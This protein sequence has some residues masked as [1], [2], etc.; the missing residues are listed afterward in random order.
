MQQT[1]RRPPAAWALAVVP[2]TVLAVVVGLL[3]TGASAP[4][5]VADPG[6][7]TRW[8]AP[9]AGALSQLAAAVVLG[10]LLLLL[11]VLVP[12]TDGARGGTAWERTRAAVTVAGPAWALLSLADLV[13]GYSTVAGRPLTDPSFGSE[14]AYYVTELS[15]GRAALVVCVMA[16][17]AA[18]A[19]VGVTGYRSGALAL[20]LATAVLIPIA[21]TGHAAGSA[22]HDLGMSALF[23]HVLAAAVWVGGLVL[24]ALVASRI[25][26]VAAVASRFSTIAGWCF[27]GIAVSGVAVSWIRLGSLDVLASGYG[28]LV[29]AKVAAFLALGLAG[30][31]HRRRTIAALGAASGRGPFWRLIGVEIALVGVASGLGAALAV[32]AAPVPQEQG[33]ELSATE[34]ISS[35]PAPP[36]PTLEAVLTSFYPD[37]VLG[38]LAVAGAVVYASWVLRLR[39]RGDRWPVARTVSWLAGV[40]M[41]GYLA[42]GAPAV[43]GHVLLSVHM[44]THMALVMLVPILLVLGAPVTLALRALPRRRDGSRGPREWLLGTLESRFARI[45]SN[46]VVAAA[47]LVGSMVVVY[48]SPLLL[49]TT[50]THIGHLLMVVHFTMT[51]YLFVNGLVGVDPGPA[52]PGYPLRLVLLLATMA[53]HA[54]FGIALMSTTQ[55]LAADYFGA[56]GLPWGVDALADQESAGEI[57]WGIGEI[58]A[59][60]LLVVLG[61]MWSRDDERLQRRTDR[62]ADRDGDADLAT[63]NAM[64]AGLSEADRAEADRGAESRPTPDRGAG[65]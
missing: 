25:D 55:L 11:G 58:P 62:A 28:A 60:I 34:V 21:T 10:G 13:L 14:L 54:F 41:F 49:L 29:I 20:V 65:R 57:A 38:G 52:R 7:V 4:T 16:A 2:V 31:W 43:Y 3:V 64:L 63:Y 30:W 45:I 15:T 46:P 24:L 33:G 51:G 39:R 36:A 32:S 18:L 23:V 47:N 26:D 53:S 22:N 48:F 17:A 40:A 37:L 50:T 6:P 44:L 9:V 1:D 27:V 19:C 8:A 5:L 61:I 59:L 35:R 56:L 12:P 42:V